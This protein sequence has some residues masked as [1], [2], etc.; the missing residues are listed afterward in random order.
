MKFIALLRGINVG[1]NNKVSMVDL[2]KAL[3]EEEF[4]NI[5]TYINSGNVIF[6]SNESNKE[7]LVKI[8]ERA[9]ENKFGFHVICSVISAKELKEALKNAPS[10]WDQNKS[11]KNNAIFVIA[12]ETADGIM[13]QVG[14]AKPDYE[15][16]SAYGP[17]IFWTAPL[18]TFSRS[19]YSKIVGTNAYKSITIRN[20]NTTKKLLELSSS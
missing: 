18:E 3:E 1:G 8:C 9:I 6:E 19:R 14:E 13:Q 15:K 20:A 10:W 5:I 12:P 2:K 17:I 16:I 7:I 11:Y 4:K